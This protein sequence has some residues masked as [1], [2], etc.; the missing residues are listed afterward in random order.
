MSTP[1]DHYLVTWRDARNGEIMTLRVRQIRDSTLGLTFV[2]LSDFVWESSSPIVNPAEEALARRFEQTKTL[3]LS[4]H[5]IV[6][7]EEIGADHQG[8]SFEK[9]RANL[10]TFPPDKR[11]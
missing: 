11:G 5:A 1:S 4:I 3:H 6:S 7:I 10:L 2:A 9:D 8:L